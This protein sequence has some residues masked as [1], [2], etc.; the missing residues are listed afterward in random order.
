MSRA[1]ASNAKICT[2]ALIS[3][4][5]NAFDSNHVLCMENVEHREADDKYNVHFIC[6][7]EDEKSMHTRTAVQEKVNG[8][9]EET[10][11][12]ICFDVIQP[13]ILRPSECN[14]Y[15]CRDCLLKCAQEQFACPIDRR[16]LTKVMLY[17]KIG[18]DVTK[19]QAMQAALARRMCRSRLFCGKPEYSKKWKKKKKKKWK[20]KFTNAFHAQY[21]SCLFQGVSKIV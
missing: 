3:P 7:V 2:R 14:H 9:E 19:E 16:R 8:I 12:P 6:P 13:P 10:E 4:I 21:C 20:K 5:V 11:C 15:F 1:D 18:G 17:D